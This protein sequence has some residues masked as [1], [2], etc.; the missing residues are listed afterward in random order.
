MTI[1][2]GQIGAKAQNYAR[3]ELVKRHRKEF[4]EIYRA[5]VIRLGGKLRPTKEDKI[6]KLKELLAELE[7]EQ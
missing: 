2:V 6:K 1:Q 7:A 4:E 5:E 3:K